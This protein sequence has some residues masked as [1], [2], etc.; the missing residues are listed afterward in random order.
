[1][2]EKPIQWKGGSRCPVVLTFDFDADELW[3]TKAQAD[4][5]YNKVSLLTRGEF[6]AFV[7]VPRVLDLLAKYGIKGCFFVPGKVAEKYPET[8]RDIYEEGHE[9]GHHGYTHSNPANFKTLEEEKEE[10]TAGIKALENVIGERP[11]GYR[12]PS[13]DLSPHTLRLLVDHEFIY[14]S[15]LINSDLPYLHCFEEKLLVEIPFSWMLDDWVYFGF[16]MSPSLP[17]QSGISSPSKVFDIW[18]SE[19]IGLYKRHRCFVLTMHPQLIGRA[20]C[21]DMLER[22]IQEIL[23]WPDVWFAQPRELAQF[24]MSSRDQGERGGSSNECC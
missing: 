21:I 8:L 7:G 4:P 15:S 11:V 9:I 20:S 22:L 14:D 16:N 13:A 10:L 1:M 2:K 12:S 5:A 24:W 6:G 23:Q 19:F 18:Y 3:R 17:Y